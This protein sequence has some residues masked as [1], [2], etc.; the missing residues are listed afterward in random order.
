MY[1]RPVLRNLSKPV[2]QLPVGASRPKDPLLRYAL[3]AHQGIL[4]SHRR[5][6]PELD[7][8]LDFQYSATGAVRSEIAGAISYQTP[9]QIFGY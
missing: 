4:A 8:V 2:R 5:K 7:V 6:P 1:I 3:P 9:T